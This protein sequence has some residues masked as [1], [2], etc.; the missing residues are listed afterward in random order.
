MC[1]YRKGFDSTNAL[2]TKSQQF[3]KAVDT[4]GQE[5]SVIPLDFS[6]DRRVSRS[7]LIH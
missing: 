6:E 3:L 1:L 4:G 7:G 2:L 5:S